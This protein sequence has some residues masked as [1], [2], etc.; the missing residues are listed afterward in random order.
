MLFML[1]QKTLGH[2]KLNAGQQDVS[3]LPIPYKMA[4]GSRCWKWQPQICVPI[5]LPNVYNLWISGK[6]SRS[7]QS[8][9]TLFFLNKKL[10]YSF[11]QKELLIKTKWALMSFFAQTCQNTLDC[12]STIPKMILLS[13]LAHSLPQARSNS[14]ALLCPEDKSQ[15]FHLGARSQRVP[16]RSPS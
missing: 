2:P 9:F 11:S 4:F 6:Y 16:V 14:S 5:F 3:P 13:Y 12:V 10:K 15:P 7:F 1:T 8:N